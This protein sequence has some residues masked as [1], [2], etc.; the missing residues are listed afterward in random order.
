MNQKNSNQIDLRNAAGA[1]AVLVTPGN[2]VQ[3]LFDAQQSRIGQSGS[4]PGLYNCIRSIIIQCDLTVVRSSG[5][6]TPIYADQFA[7]SV[8]SIGLTT[9][10][11]GT[12][13]DPTVVNG[14]VAKELIEYPLLGYNRAGLNR[15]PIPGSDGTYTRTFEIELPYSDMRNENPDQFAHWLGWLDQSILEIFVQSGSDPFGVSTG[16]SITNVNFTVALNMIPW[17]EIIIPPFGNVRQYK[18]AASASSNGPKLIGVG[19]AGALQGVDDSARLDMMVFS[20][21]AGGFVGSG[22]ADGITAI[23]MP[24]RDQA[25]S[26][27]PALFFERY[28]RAAR[29]FRPGW[30]TAVNAEVSD[31]TVPYIMPNS[32]TGPLNSFNARYTPF[33][34]Q[35][36]GSQ[37]SYM[38]KVKG[39][40]PLDGMTFGSTQTGSFVVYTRELKQYSVQKCSEMLAAMGVD[41]TKVQLVPKLAKKNVKRV[42]ANKVFCFPRQVVLKT[43]AAA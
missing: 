10:L 9:P 8:A 23:S 5:G 3:Y 22:T 16:V 25:Q 27:L 28:L 41:P 17:P 34:W 29:Q 2:S 30:S 12:Q 6:T 33:V 37:I 19:D 1:R 32:F 24:W 14:M 35:E 39:N 20:H 7:R 18:I 43:P 11:F 36:R 26:T 4:G 15:Q 42:N 40:Y 31:M 21:Q 38:Q 13:Y